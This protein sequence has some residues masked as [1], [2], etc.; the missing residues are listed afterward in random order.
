[1]RKQ[2]KSLYEAINDHPVKTR[3]VKR[4]LFFDT[5]MN[6]GLNGRKECRFWEW[7]YVWAYV[8]QV[9]ID[10]PLYGANKKWC[11][12]CFVPDKVL[13]LAGVM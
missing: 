10:L 12:V 11:D 3:V 7:A 6:V 4:F 5:I 1:M 8:C 2:V 13:R 9:Y